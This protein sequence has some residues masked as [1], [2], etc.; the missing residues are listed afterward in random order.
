MDRNTIIGI[1]LIGGILVAYSM[2]TKPQREKMKDASRLRDSL[3][4]VEPRN[5]QATGT[6][7]I[8]KT[9]SLSGKDQ[10]VR[11]G[12]APEQ[13]PGQHQGNAE[14]LISQFGVFGEAAAGTEEYITVETDLLKVVL[15]TKGGRIYSVELKEYL[16]YDG[17]PLILFDGDSTIF[18]LNFF[19]ANRS[20]NTTEL[21]FQPS[22]AGEYISIQDSPESITMRLPAGDDSYIDYIYTFNPGRYL[23]DFTI[24]FHN[25]EDVIARNTSFI[26]LNWEYYAAGHEQGRINEMNYTNIFFKHFEDEVDKFN[27]RSKKDVQAQDITTRLRWIGFKQHFF[28]SVI[29]ADN[30]FNNAY[31]SIRKFGET[32]PYLKQFSSQIGLPYEAKESYEFPMKL[33]FGPNHYQTLKKYDLELENLMQ[34]GGWFSRT[35]NRYLIIPIF[36]WLN[37]FIN[38]YGI[39]ILVLTLI[40]KIGLFPLTYRSY[41]S[42]AKMRVL[43]PEIDE[44]NAKIP[45]EKSMERQQATMALYK[46]AGVSPLGG[47]LPMVLQMPILIAMFRFFPTSIELRQEK[48]LWATDLSTYDSIL[49]L[50]WDIP[51]YGDHVSLFTILMTASTILTMKISNQATASQT[52]MPGM[53]GMMYIMPVMFMF[54]LNSFSAALTYY[55]FLANIIT[56]G[57]NLIFKQF[58]DE[59]A[60]RRKIQLNQKKKSGIAKKSSFQKRM[61]NMARQRGNPSKKRK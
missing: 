53:K 25:T 60:L 14:D 4:L 56:F 44:I 11:T 42:M 28:S 46:K 9:E 57:Q 40:I 36:N 41:L 37:R 39:I 29:I 27:S 38:S 52:Q 2:F 10:P 45:K 33:F 30:S 19:A 58:V 32:D 21:F 55:Y 22:V 5:L 23:I 8:T 35:F 6:D 13:V 17:F 15:A 49:D 50:P 18:G 43:K 12:R 1:I 31:L 59:D 16:T 26:D 48:W 61:E 34:L 51:M 20:I 47:C 7:A 3:E 54:I 24:S